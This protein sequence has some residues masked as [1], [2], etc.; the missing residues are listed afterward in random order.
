[1]FDEES[2]I[3]HRKTQ[4]C[5]SNF[6]ISYKDLSRPYHS[7][8]E[9]H[10]DHSLVLSQPQTHP[11]WNNRLQD[12]E[13]EDP[14]PRDGATLAEM[15][16]IVNSI[17]KPLLKGWT[18]R[19]QHVDPTVLVTYL[20]SAVVDFGTTFTRKDVL[21]PT[22]DMINQV[23]N[24]INWMTFLEKPENLLNEKFVDLK[25]TQMTPH[26]QRKAVRAL[27]K[28]AKKFKGLVPHRD[29]PRIAVQTHRPRTFVR[30]RDIMGMLHSLM[31]TRKRRVVHFALDLY[32]ILLAGQRFLADMK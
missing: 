32:A 25:L 14:A 4:A 26:R 8:Q 16:G 9:R 7:A 6:S 27:N 15:M 19:H 28:L 11:H 21:V 5:R 22:W 1:M 3:R 12:P 31:A 29:P 24:S 2:W 23:D 17:L 10:P 20:T 13:F 30:I 18:R